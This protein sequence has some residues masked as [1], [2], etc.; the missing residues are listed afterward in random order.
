MVATASSST[1][2]QAH[3]TEPE[4]PDHESP[5]HESHGGHPG[6]VDADEPSAAWGWHGSFP[7]GGRVAGWVTTVGIF[8]MAFFSHGGVS[9]NWWLLP[10]GAAL[11]VALIASEVKQRRTSQR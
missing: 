10:I 1:D 8:C 11:V 2:E 5:D 6:G 4:S 7:V 3:S 9:A